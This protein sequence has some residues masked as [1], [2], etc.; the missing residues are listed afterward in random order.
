MKPLKSFELDVTALMSEII[1]GHG[2]AHYGYFPKGLPDDLSL[3]TLGQAQ[4]DYLE[5]IVEVLPQ[6]AHRILDVG[7]GTGANA[8]A[9]VERGF[10]VSCVSPSHQMNE[11]ARAKLPEGTAVYDAFFETFDIPDTFDLCLFT[12]SLH[13]IN[14]ED[15]LKQ[16]A[17][18]AE[19]GVV[20]F[21]YFRRP[22]SEYSD[23]TRGLHGEF[24]EKVADQGFFEIVSDDDLTASIT[25]TFMIHE[26]IKNN[27]FIPFF[28]RL[29]TQIRRQYPLRGWLAER[30]FGRFMNK[31]G[32]QSHSSTKF[33]REKEYRLIVMKRRKP[34]D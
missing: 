11:M 22:G 3:Q 32:R 10:E 21:D 23:G 15:A 17:R 13:Y 26:H 12:E 1:L 6:K 29:R 30:F 4:A 33:A 25:P 19:H 24:L 7:S 9:L 31:L 28:N 2:Y 27:L 8:R 18:Y 34:M 16:M 5:K 20:I 14:L